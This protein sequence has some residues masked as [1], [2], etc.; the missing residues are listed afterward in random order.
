MTVVLERQTRSVYLDLP[1]D[2]KAFAIGGH[3]PLFRLAEEEGLLKLTVSFI[4]D[5]VLPIVALVKKKDTAT[6]RKFR[7]A[8]QAESEVA[9]EDYTFSSYVSLPYIEIKGTSYEVFLSTYTVLG[10]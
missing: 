4:P 9:S 3:S 5:R 10:F 2:V 6:P 8:Y 7:K 1:A